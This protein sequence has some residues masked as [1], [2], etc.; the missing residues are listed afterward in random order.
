M[1]KETIEE[2]AT[3]EAENRY[4]QS[5]VNNAPFTTTGDLYDLVKEVFECG[6]NWQAN[7]QWI[8]VKDR[9]PEGPHE[10]LTINYPKV[11][12][13]SVAVY[14]KGNEI[15]YQN[16]NDE[17]EFLTEGWYELEETPMSDHEETWTERN[18][19]HW[20]TLPPLPVM[21]LTT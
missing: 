15:E 5:S 2:V 1:N 13:Q 20:Q 10:V 9:L 3:A 14:T 6:A 4:P 12:H 18:V 11:K 7:Q 21:P 16:N 19:T 17:P 8:D